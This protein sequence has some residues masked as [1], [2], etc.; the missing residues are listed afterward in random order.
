MADGWMRVAGH[1]ETP[2]LMHED[3]IEIANG[4][5]LMG[6]KRWTCTNARCDK[7]LHNYVRNVI[8]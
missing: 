6:M 3:V 5:K 4:I 1:A 7:S 8:I 2:N